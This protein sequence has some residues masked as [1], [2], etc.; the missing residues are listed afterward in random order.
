MNIK[1]LHFFFHEHRPVSFLFM[2]IDRISSSCFTCTPEKVEKTF[3]IRVWW[4]VFWKDLCRKIPTRKIEWTNLIRHN[5]HFWFRFLI[6]LSSDSFPMWIKTNEHGDI[7]HFLHNW[8]TDCCNIT[9]TLIKW[10][11]MV[12]FLRIF[13]RN[14]CSFT[15][16]AISLEHEHCYQWRACSTW[17]PASAVRFHYYFYFIFGS[18][19]AIYKI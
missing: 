19:K 9:Y 14:D 7:S 11:S 1:L 2:N 17:A 8:R 10:S 12:G 5:Q 15:M 18:L 3:S 16:T 13:L 4:N 6:L